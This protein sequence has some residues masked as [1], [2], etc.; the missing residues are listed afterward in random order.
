[1]QHDLCHARGLS[2]AFDLLV[3]FE[4]IGGHDGAEGRKKYVYQRLWARRS[5]A[6]CG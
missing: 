1:V 4:M 2:Q 6:G 5:A 3:I